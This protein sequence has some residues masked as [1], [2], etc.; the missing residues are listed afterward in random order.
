M[1]ASLL[2]RF[3]ADGALAGR[4]LASGDARLALAALLV[5]VARI[6]GSYEAAETR[7]I[8]DVLARRHGLGAAAAAALRARAEALEADAADTVR[9]TRAL[10]EAVPYEERAAL[11]ETLWEVVLADGGRSSEE[12]AELRLVAGLL[13]IPDRDSGLARQRVEARLGR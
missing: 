5:R 4:T 6:D 2:R 3:A 7:G 8:D 12:D 13:G 1:F 11:L 10:K 9:F